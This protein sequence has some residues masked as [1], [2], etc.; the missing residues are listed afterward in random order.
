MD[1]TSSLIWGEVMSCGRNLNGEVLKFSS[2]HSVT[3]IFFRKKLVV[4][5]NILMRPAET[6]LIGIGHLE[7]YT[8]QATLIF[9]GEVVDIQG[10]K[11][12]IVSLLEAFDNLEFGI[13]DLP[14]HGIIV[15]LLG[16]KAEQ[17]FDLLKKV[18]SVFYCKTKESYV[19]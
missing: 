8:H 1:E 7:G 9:V 3:E 17:L 16:R 18:S 11:E 13:S 5:E 10:K 14:V 4:K 12:D 15:R 6:N 2:Y 19:I